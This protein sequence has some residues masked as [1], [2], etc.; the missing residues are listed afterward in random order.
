M[1]YAARHRQD[2]AG[3]SDAWPY[4][5]PDVHAAPPQW[6][7]LPSPST[8]YWPVVQAVAATRRSCSWSNLLGDQSSPGSTSLTAGRRAGRRGPVVTEPGIDI[9]TAVT[10]SKLRPVSVELLHPGA[11]SV[12]RGSM[13]RG[14]RCSSSSARRRRRCLSSSLIPVRASE[15]RFSH[16]SFSQRSI[17]PFV[18][19]EALQLRGDLVVV[20]LAVRLLTQHL[21][22]LWPVVALDAVDVMHVF[23]ATQWPP[24]YSRC[25]HAV[26]W[27]EALSHSSTVF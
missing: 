13:S 22:I 4:A 6:A 1:S 15:I 10:R 2:R 18:V 19:G 7:K 11:G 12:A 23:T 16:G 3:E 14:S 21:E 27:M 8:T 17:E 5:L 20:Q 25:D 24:Q 26:L 9:S